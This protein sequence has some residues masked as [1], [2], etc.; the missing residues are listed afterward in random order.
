MSSKTSAI[1][2][3]EIRTNLGNPDRNVEISDAKVISV[4]NSALVEFNKLVGVWSFKTLA[5]S[6]SATTYDLETLLTPIK[7]IDVKKVCPPY[8]GS[9]IEEST[10]VLENQSD[11]LISSTTTN[12][13]EAV[14]R[15]L[16]IDTDFPFTYIRPNLMINP[17]SESN[18]I[19]IVIQEPAILT[20]LSDEDELV[21]TEYAT[22]M[23]EIIVARARCRQATPMRSG[24]LTLGYGRKEEVL[25]ADAKELKKKFE[26]D[27]KSIIITRMM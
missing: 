12:S 9:V 26:D 7:V 24:D 25:L 16:A 22:A 21:V 2:L 14:M 5:I 4:W 23:C 6:A 10:E 11:F 20:T 8:K 17:P 13:A 15:A 27:C 3:E 18:T 19:N 1:L